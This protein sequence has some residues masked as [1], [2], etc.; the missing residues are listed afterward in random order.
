M[1]ILLSWVTDVHSAYIVHSKLWGVTM[2]LLAPTVDSIIQNFII[3]NY[4]E[5]VCGSST[6]K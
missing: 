5:M 6:A 2:Q 3:N 1:S 4:Y